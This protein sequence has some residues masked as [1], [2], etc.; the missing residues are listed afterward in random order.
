[1]FV[2]RHIF[3]CFASAERFIAAINNI[4]I[5]ITIIIVIINW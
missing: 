2:H 3:I 4:I 1:M 5:R